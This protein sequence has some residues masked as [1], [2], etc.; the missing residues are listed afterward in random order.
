ML[1]SACLIL[2]LFFLA[3]CSQHKVILTDQEYLK[4]GQEYLADED[5]EEAR[6]AFEDLEANH[7]DSPR[8][9][10]A[11]MGQAEAYFE[12]KRYGEAA[13]EYKR[14]LRFH[15]RN[16]LADKAQYQLGLSYF[17]QRFSIDRDTTH[18]RQALGAFTALMGQYPRSPL[19]SKAQEK[20]TICFEELAEHEFYVG[21]FYFKQEDYEA[22]SG[23]LRRLCLDYPQ[24]KAAAKGLFYLAET[25]WQL[26]KRAEARQLFKLFLSKYPE[27][28]HTPQA[29]QRIE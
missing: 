12:E 4:L 15:P 6:Q 23:R 7:P 5:Y 17:N 16:A 9:V 20:R 1:R 28:E 13:L 3:A 22:A 11:R 18:T 10:Q 2:I 19:L 14:F 24:T 8:V 21:H 25:H 26:G 27:H 29:R